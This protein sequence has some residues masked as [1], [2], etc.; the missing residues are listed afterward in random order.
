MRI[1][2]PSISACIGSLKTNILLC[3]A[4]ALLFGLNAQPTRLNPQLFTAIQPDTAPAAVTNFPR[5]FHPHLYF[6]LRPNARV[7][8]ESCG[9][10][11]EL[12]RCQAL[13]PSH[14]A[15]APAAHNSHFLKPTVSVG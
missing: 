7:F 13:Q 9:A 4:M 14:N 3:E 8:V 11:H 12:G 10:L 15:P 6:G 2:V 5:T 1:A